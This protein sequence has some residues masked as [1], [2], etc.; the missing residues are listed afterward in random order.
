VGLQAGGEDAEH[1]D[2]CLPGGEGSRCLAAE[3][4]GA[5]IEDGQR[6]ERGQADQCGI[7]A[8]GRAQADSRPRHAGAGPVSAHSD[9]GGPHG[10]DGQHGGGCPVQRDRRGAGWPGEA[11]AP[12]DRDQGI[13]AVDGG[14]PQTGRGTDAHGRP[15]AQAD[16]HN[17]DRAHRHS[18]TVAR[19]EPGQRRILHG[20]Q[21]IPYSLPDGFHTRAKGPDGASA[22]RRNAAAAGPSDL[23]GTP[24]G[25]PLAGLNTCRFRRDRFFVIPR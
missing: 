25:G 8:Q 10:Q 11:G 13:G 9:H 16:P 5:K 2:P 17:G 24:L 1:E 14:H 22:D 21:A 4:Q 20:N 23:R 19:Q 18:D 3:H 7:R 15:G 6:V 12:G